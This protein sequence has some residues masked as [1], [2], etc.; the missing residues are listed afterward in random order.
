M[1]EEGWR[2]LGQAA[3]LPQGELRGFK[4]GS[5]R[6]CVGRS[7]DRYFAIEDTCP[8]AGGS[9]SEGMIEDELVICPLHAFA[10]EAKTGHCPDDPG[11][12]VD[13][14]EVRVQDGVLQVRL[15]PEPG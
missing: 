11:C 8:H 12:S 3:E 14:F 10:F 13:A 6:L 4:V 9:L 15:G 1:A 2:S 7:G 5:R